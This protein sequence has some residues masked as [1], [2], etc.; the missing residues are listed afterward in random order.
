MKQP[1]KNIISYLLLAIFLTATTPD[2]LLHLLTNHCDTIDSNSPDISIA[3]KH[4]H[5]EALQ[6][7]LP[8][9]SESVNYCFS[10]LSAG[11]TPLFFEFGIIRI[12]SISLRPS[13]RAPPVLV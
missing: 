3:A 4:V 13:S 5:C 12:A 8:A 6:L 11:S 1:L 7:S 9:F 10:S 2:N